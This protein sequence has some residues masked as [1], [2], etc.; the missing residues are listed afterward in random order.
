M[1]VWILVKYLGIGSSS[2]RHLWITPPLRMCL[3]LIRHPGDTIILMHISNHS[4]ENCK[5]VLESF[6]VDVAT[7]T[8]K[9]VSVSVVM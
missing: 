7:A 4:E 1:H 5:S 3:S 2:Y 8:T 6:T 9:P